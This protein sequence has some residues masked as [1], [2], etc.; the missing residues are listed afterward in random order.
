MPVQV[1]RNFDMV[2]EHNYKPGTRGE[3]V[4]FEVAKHESLVAHYE[5]AVAGGAVELAPR[6]EQLRGDLTAHKTDQTPMVI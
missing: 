2:G 6:L 1:I 4:H 3:E 5:T